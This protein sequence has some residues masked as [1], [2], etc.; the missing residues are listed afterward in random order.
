MVFR[1]MYGA[2]GDVF[3]FAFPFAPLDDHKS[4]GSLLLSDSLFARAHRLKTNLEAG[5]ASG[6]DAVWE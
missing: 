1:G 2:V 6:S 4:I 5:I 3:R